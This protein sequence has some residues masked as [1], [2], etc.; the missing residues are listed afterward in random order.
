MTGT[1]NRLK[2]IPLLKEFVPLLEKEVRKWDGKVL[3][4]RFYRA[5]ET[6]AKDWYS[7]QG[8]NGENHYG[9]NSAYIHRRK[10]KWRDNSFAINLSVVYDG[11]TYDVL[12]TGNEQE[13]AVLETGKAPRVNADAVIESMERLERE[14]ADTLYTIMNTLNHEEELKEIYRM[15]GVLAKK[16]CK[17][18]YSRKVMVDSFGFSQSTLDHIA[19]VS[20][21]R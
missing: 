15:I 19:D 18:E 2:M 21:M 1:E 12:T 4:I 8:L 9:L 14:R 5:L 16:L 7:Q 11:M 20:C 3:N 17:D 13:W 6:F 10:D